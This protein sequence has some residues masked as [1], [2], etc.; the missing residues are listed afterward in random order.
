MLTFGSGEAQRHSLI[1][2]F[3]AR[4]NV[5]L[6]NSNFVILALLRSH[7]Y[8]GAVKVQVGHAYPI[9]YATTMDAPDQEG[10]E[11][12]DATSF[13]ESENPLEWYQT[14]RP[15]SP[16]E[17]GSG[18][19]GKKKKGGAADEWRGL[20]LKP[21]SGVGHYSPSL[22]EHCLLCAD[23]NPKEKPPSFLTDA[24]WRRLQEILRSEGGRI[25]AD[26]ELADAK[27]Y[28]FY[29]PKLASDD[30]EKDSAGQKSLPA[31]PFD[32]KLLLEFQPH[33]L[34]QHEEMPKIEFE[35]FDRAVDA[36]FAQIEGQKRVL[37]AE[38]QQVQAEQR[39]EKAKKEQEQRIQQLFEQ[40]ELLKEQA[41]L[42]ETH[43]DMVDKAIQV[44]N[45]ALDS[46]MDWD[47]L[48]DLV[49]VEKTQNQNPVALLIKRL[50]LEHDA[51]VLSL[52]KVDHVAESEGDGGD[53]SART[54]D[55]TIKPCLPSIAP[56][57]RKVKRRSK[58]HPKFSKLPKSLL[59]VDYRM[60]RS[61][62]RT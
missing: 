3:Y 21:A 18:N 57:R 48:E 54:M 53:E 32:D 38:T 11:A 58:Q 7:D 47:Q 4:G 23:I 46:G 44:V 1:L 29:Q 22:I 52:E 42:V 12:Q 36:F 33:V 35:S 9:T 14:H 24:D 19:K 16:D 5:I 60:H 59:N 6:T 10:N 20:L 43:A 61:E 50:D 13:I 41:Q 26:M 31:T 25:L 40:Q 15:V 8:D 2:E 17:A 55:V 30:G 27:G 37:R 62:R 39:L 51:M 34:K 28:I 56:A 45:S 49:H